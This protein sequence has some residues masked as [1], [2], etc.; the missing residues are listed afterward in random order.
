M[1]YSLRLVWYVLRIILIAASAFAMLAVAFFVAMDS[2]NVFVVVTD[3]MKAKATAVLMPGQGADLGKFFTERYLAGD[4]TQDRSRYAD[5][6]IK[7]FDYRIS[8]ES[9][10]CNPWK[11]TATVTVVESIP[12]I[13]YSGTA[14]AT[15]DGGK[16]S[17]EPPQWPR[18]KYRILCVRQNDVWRI[19]GV[20]LVQSLPPEPTP[21]PEPSV[22]ITASPVP[23]ATPS[24]VASPQA[25]ASA[26]AT[27]Q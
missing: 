19:D 1:K 21:S 26:Q 25:S 7:D 10:W 22:Y 24:A 17:A 3:G 6:V 5:F 8:V 4:P 15:E 18:A 16:P 23:T 11:D 14:A 2:A 20:E 9:L 27:A 13:F 12:T